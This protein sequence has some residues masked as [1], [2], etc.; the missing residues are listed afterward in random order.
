MIHGQDLTNILVAKNYCSS[1][2]K[3]WN[4]YLS[5]EQMQT[6][7]LNIREIANFYLGSNNIAVKKCVDHNV[8][9]WIEKLK[10]NP[11]KMDNDK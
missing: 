6:N 9:N 7:E 2:Q 10:E 11:H 1:P 4:Q 3:L 8:I 5:T